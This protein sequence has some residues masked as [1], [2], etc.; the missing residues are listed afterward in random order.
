MCWAPATGPITNIS[1]SAPTANI[2]SANSPL[3]LKKAITNAG[4]ATLAARTYIVS[5]AALVRTTTSRSGEI[6]LPR[7]ILIN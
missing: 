7:L 3:T 2:I 4:C 5:F 1:L 6:S